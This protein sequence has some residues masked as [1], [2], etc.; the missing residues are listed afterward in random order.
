MVVGSTHDG[1]PD[2]YL[3]PCLPFVVLRAAF[4]RFDMRLVTL[5]IL[6]ICGIVSNRLTE[7]ANA[8]A[9]RLIANAL[10]PLAC[11][12]GR[13]AQRSLL[14]GQQRLLP[15]GPDCALHSQRMAR[16]PRM[17]HSFLVVC[18][19]VSAATLVVNL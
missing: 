8:W 2:T 13:L 11:S 5:E 17:L 9:K 14:T 18:R 4:N 10:L 19:L 3:C 12:A 16:C 1:Q 6:G 7:Q 15:F